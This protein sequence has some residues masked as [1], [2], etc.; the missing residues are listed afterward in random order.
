MKSSELQ[1]ILACVQLFD[2][3]GASTLRDVSGLVVP[4]QYKENTTLFLQDADA[5]GFFVLV[6][7]SITVY[8]TGMDG[9]QQI[10]HVFDTMGDVCGEV[11]VFEGGQYP[12]TADVTAQTELLYVPRDAFLRLAQRHP[13][14]LM[15]MLAI[16]S[17]RLR[18]FVNLID[19]LS[20]KAVV[21]RLA[22][23]L[24]EEMESAGSV[25]IMLRIP[26]NM[27]AARLGTIA[28]TVSRS[29]R[30]LQAQGVIEVDGRRIRVLDRTGL[31]DVAEGG[32]NL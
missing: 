5:H 31:A 12:A 23:Y 19:D 1:Q 25:N 6:R 7:G 4:K 28:E 29:F 8:R 14:I 16:L 21:S 24:L 30:K 2:G 15:H 11:P 18:R 3:L 26:K 9:R 10:L 17:K 22:K 32:M 27:L 20:L 13:E